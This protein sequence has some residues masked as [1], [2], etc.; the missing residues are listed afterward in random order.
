[1]AINFGRP[2]LPPVERFS[3]E[4]T[5]E[6]AIGKKVIV[7]LFAHFGKGLGGGGAIPDP[8]PVLS[9]EFESSVAAEAFATGVKIGLATM[10]DAVREAIQGLKI[11]QVP[12]V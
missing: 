6:S 2:D 12:I 8:H 5:D 7:T 10:G 1:M 9:R 4:T 3:V 11:P